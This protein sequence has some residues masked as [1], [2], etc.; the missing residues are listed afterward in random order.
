MDKDLL[1][2]IMEVMSAS[3]YDVREYAGTPLSME[4][5]IE[6]LWRDSSMAEWVI[7]CSNFR[8]NHY[9]VPTTSHDLYDMI[10]DLRDDISEEKPGC[11]CA[12]CGKPVHPRTGSWIHAY[13]EKRWNF[14]G[15]HV[16]QII[17]PMH[18]ASKSKWSVL[19]GK[20]AGKGNTQP[21]QFDNEVLGESSDTGSRMI[22]MTD[23]QKAGTLGWNSTLPEAKAHLGRYQYRVMAVDW[24]GGGQEGVSFTTLAAMGIRPDGKIECFWGHRSLTPHDHIR[25]A[26]LVLKAMG[27]LQCHILAHDYNGAGSLR[28]TLIHQAGVPL[29]KIVPIQYVRAAASSIMTFKPST[30]QHPRDHY[31]VDK[32][33]S[34]LLTCNHIKQGWLKF[35]NYDYKDADEQGL[36]HD[37][38]AL[39]EEK[40]DSRTGKDIYTII[41]DPHRI[42]DFAQAVN[43]GCCALWHMTNKWPN[44]AS[45]TKYKMSQE[46]LDAV[47][48]L[49][50]VEWDDL[51][52]F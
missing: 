34:L 13:P 4:N 8:C 2:V 41:R 11:I 16:P 38:L 25:E 28:E 6:G 52:T 31:S 43:F 44:I 30:L 32:T 24:G 9:N 35:F 1:P 33:R 50:E 3:R 15:Y 45:M 10:G 39:V 17:M 26:K 23:L 22:T 40:S 19:L 5:T 48:P 36:L 20:R 37:F 14:S 47:H 27:D 51:G 18:Y 29:E 46:L 21:H 49:G 7:K 12:K 42:D